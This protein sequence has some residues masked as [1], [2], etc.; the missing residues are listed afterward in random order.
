[1]KKIVLILLVQLS[2]T[3]SF[4][5]TTLDTAVNF[6]V[7]DIHGQML[8]L[9][10][11]LD[12]DKYVVIDFF[13]VACGTCQTYAPDMAEAYEA[14]GCNQGNVF[15]LGIDKG[16]WNEDVIYFNNEYGIE[17]SSVSGM[18]GNGNEVHWTYD[19]QGTPSVVVIAPD[20]SIAVHQ[21]Y[22]PAANNLINS[23]TGAG[24]VQQSC[25]TGL[26]ENEMTAGDFSYYP[27]PVK[28]KLNCSVQAQ[29]GMILHVEVID[30][31]GKTVAT[32]EEYESREGANVIPVSL[33]EVK[34]GMYIAQVK[35]RDIILHSGKIIVDR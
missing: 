6:T 14:F 25:T 18:E 27:N 26:Y 22:P 34:N 3:F 1:M 16:N 30:L 13:S 15:F 19:I 35:N 33:T 12:N 17:Y 8:T 21:V 11:I 4:S 32:S 29:K 2:L 23:I 9:F 5:Q 28:E 31:L 20:R 10:D 24:G 7:K